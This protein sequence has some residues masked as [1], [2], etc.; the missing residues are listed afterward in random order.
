MIPRGY[1]SEAHGYF[2]EFEYERQTS[3]S[4][5]HL[6]SGGGEKFAFG[7]GLELLARMLARF[8]QVQ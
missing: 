1:W 8:R 2:I 3:L 7:E 4:S 6:E 5:T